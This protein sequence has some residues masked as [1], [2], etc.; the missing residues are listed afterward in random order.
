MTGRGKMTELL[1]I[2]GIRFRP[3]I[4]IMSVASDIGEQ[5]EKCPC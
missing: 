2:K 3:D 4:H 1:D 5:H